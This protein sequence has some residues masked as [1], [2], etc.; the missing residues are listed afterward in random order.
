M[1]PKT[2]TPWNWEKQKE[3]NAVE[4]N[5]DMKCGNMDRILEQQEQ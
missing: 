1:K 4:H 3:Q 2:I 5:N